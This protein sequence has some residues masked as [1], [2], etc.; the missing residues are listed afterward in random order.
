MENLILQRL[1]KFI[2]KNNLS[3]KN[4]AENVDST[5]STFNTMFQR[6]SNPGTELLIKILA[7]YPNLSINWLLNGIGEMEIENNPEIGKNALSVSN[8][9]LRL[10]NDLEK[11]KELKKKVPKTTLE[12]INKIAELSAEL[13]IEKEKNKTLEENKISYGM[14][15]EK[16]VKYGK[17]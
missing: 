13:A 7:K 15:A 9:L 17:Q 14:A 3:I 11:S 12:L 8:S 1:R 4:F 2:K 16:I 6:E 10:T 5:E